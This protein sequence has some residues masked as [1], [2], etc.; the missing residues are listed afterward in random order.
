MALQ[1]PIDELIGSERSDAEFY[2]KN[3][4]PTVVRTGVE[5]RK[6]LPDTIPG[7]LID[8][9]EFPPHST[10]VGIPH[11]PGTRE[12]LACEAGRIILAAGG[13]K[14]ELE[15]GDVV[16]FRGDQ[17]HS[18]RNPTVGTAIGYSVVMFVAVR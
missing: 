3:K 6:L 1:V 13:K 8:R 9:M 4:I 5:L 17:R 11:T 10:L 2:P 12:Y 16:A 15:A 14:W 18:Y 7:V